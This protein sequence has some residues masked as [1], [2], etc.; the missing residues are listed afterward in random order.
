MTRMIGKVEYAN[1]ATE[2][3]QLLKAYSA[4]IGLPW[5]V[6]GQRQ[7]DASVRIAWVE[8]KYN[9]LDAAK[10]T[11]EDDLIEQRRGE[12]VAERKA[13][14]ADQ[15]GALVK[16]VGAK[17]T[18]GELIDQC[19]HR[20]EQASPPDFTFG[21]DMSED[22]YAAFRVE[23]REAGELADTRNFDQFTDFR[24][25]KIQDKG[26]LG[27]GQVG[28]TLDTRRWQGNVFLTVLGAEFNAHINIRKKS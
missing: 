25:L 3:L 9:G 17:T 12:R 28:D 16:A 18:A 10:K 19:K 23:W 26:A 27:K 20:Y 1:D 11:L 6:I 24:A 7:R 21:P 15:G 13:A 2:A 4:Q 22:D 14:I 8:D 5:G